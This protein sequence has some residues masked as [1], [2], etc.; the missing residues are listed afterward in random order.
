[1]KNILQIDLEDWYC[2]IDPKEWHCQESR[3][4]GATEKVLSIL[5]DTRSKAT[6]FVLGYV[7]EQSPG[8]IKTIEGAGHEIA[9]HGYGHRRITDQAPDEFR[10]DLQR[11][12]RILMEITGEKVTGYRAPQ[13]TVMKET[14]WA[15]DI[16]KEEGMT[17]DSSIFPVKTPLY[18]LP[19]STLFPYTI[20][21]DRIVD[22]NGLIE[23]PLSVYRVPLLEKRIPIAGGFYLRFFPYFFIRHAINKLNKAGNVAVCYVHPWEFDPDKPRIDSLKWYHYYRLSSTE[24][25]FRKLTEEFEFISTKEWIE[26]WKNNL[27]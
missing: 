20:G 16:L 9:T 18:G 5:E 3:V 14:L 23:I 21:H 4:I 7:A 8:L 27:E 25:K 24:A 19:D 12:L 13:F 2:D 22:G 6:F 10:E 1:M 15:L 17:Y 11:S 26:K